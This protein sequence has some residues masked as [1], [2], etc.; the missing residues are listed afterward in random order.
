M[1]ERMKCRYPVRMCV[2][3]RERFPKRELVRHVCPADRSDGHLVPDAEQLAP[4]RGFYICRRNE[5]R[6]RFPKFKGWAARCKGVMH[7]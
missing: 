3:C 1:T 5:C 2:I 6:Q 7:G 4:G